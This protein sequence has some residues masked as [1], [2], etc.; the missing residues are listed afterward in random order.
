[1]AEPSLQLTGEFRI[2][3]TGKVAAIPAQLTR[4]VGREREIAEVRALVASSRLLTLTGAGG[5]G[6]TRLAL[7]V[8]ARCA[9]DFPHGV[10]WVELAPL[11]DPE[12]LADHV[13]A[14]L[15]VRMEGSASAEEAIVAAL[16]GQAMLLALDNCEHLVDAC[17]QLVGTLLRRCSRLR[18]LATSREPLGIGGERSWLV[19][20]LAVPGAEAGLTADRA[21]ESP[22]VR[23]FVDRARDVLPSFALTDAN[24]AAVARICRRVDGL[25]LAIELAAARVRLLSPEQIAQRLDEGFRLLD[26]GARAA[27]PRHRT[28]RAAIEWSYRLLDER[29]RRLLERLAVFAGDWS[30]DAAESV[31]AEDDAESWAVLDLLAA[32]VDKSLVMV[33]ESPGTARFGMLETIRQFAAERLE[34]RGA[35]HATHARH[36]RFY[37]ALVAEAEPDFITRRRRE[38]VE[39]V[40]RELDN[41][42]AALVWTRAHDPALHLRLAGMLTWLWY[43]V[44][45]WTE[46]RRWLEGALA[47]PVPPSPTAAADRARALF[48]AGAF[49]SLQADAPSARA[50]LEEA[51]ALALDVGDARLAAYASSYL[52]MAHTQQLSLAGEPYLDEALLWFRDAGDA[53][54]YRLALLLAATLRLA[55]GR[56]DD[57]RA[58][59]EEG[60]AV[61]RDFG[62]DRE[63]G[64]AT[65]V[66]GHVALQSGDLARADALMR[67]SLRALLRDPQ[68][69]FTGRA[70]DALGLVSCGRGDPIAGA[71]FFGAADREREFI[72]AAVWRVDRD[73]LAP[74]VERAR[75]AAGA[76][77]FDAAR[78]EGRTMD[79]HEVAA[80]APEPPPSAA[81]AIDVR[82]HDSAPP[83]PALRV[84]ALGPLEV[85][86]DGVRMPA[87]AWRYAKP[88]ELL[89]YLLSHPAGR[90]REQVGLV[91]WPDASA[92]QVKNNF[93]VTL[94]HLRKVLGRA[95]CIVFEGD[96]YRVNDAIGVEFD[97]AAFER[98][99]TA[100]LRALARARPDERASAAEPLLAALARYRGDFLEDAA[101]GDWHLAI[102]DRLQRLWM[103]G[104]LAAGDALAAAERHDEAAAAYDALLARDPLH[105]EAA[106]RL[107]TSASRLGD[108]ARALRAYERL[109]ASL[110][111]ELD[112]APERATVALHERLRRA[113]VV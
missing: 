96:R 15:G 48:G 24:A 75:A 31:G 18:V 77:A 81:P 83:A 2:A 29:E 6:K 25:P 80:G 36:A 99:A 49:A 16:R 69:L 104:M 39:H 17:A 92:P 58:A 52:A 42:R 54:G 74:H 100:A 87:E 28:L 88:R 97:A 13:A 27:L 60:V 63:L 57:A 19:P 12:H 98:D 40:A 55:Q 86:R 107:M 93:H 73:R 66:L 90:T 41:V 44:G 108:R 21:T 46:G 53:Y 67:E 47:A 4:L 7:E 45:F 103:D 43:S 113:E 5:S 82:E 32:L 94:H 95:D 10:V 14:A 72:G 85:H 9:A 1:M 65:Q 38:A 59:A 11:V 64:I 110:R 33:H 61:A 70:L 3:A 71:R 30:L 23:L 22:A 101:A 112:A 89:L 102:R 34:E 62:L 79:L 51:R 78:A 37:A 109:A 35:A 91:F 50:W 111:A 84:L 68:P 56:L 106:R 26:G 20:V 8:V 105:E 76:A